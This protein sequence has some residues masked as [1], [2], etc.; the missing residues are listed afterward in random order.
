MRELLID[1]NDKHNRS[2][3]LTSP[4]CQSLRDHITTS[5]CADKLTSIDQYIDLAKFYFTGSKLNQLTGFDQFSHVDVILGCTQ[6]I[7]SLLIRYGLSGLQIL[8]GD[9]RYYWRLNPDL[10]TA[11]VGALEPNK[12]LLISMPFV[13]VSDIHPNMDSI[14]D[15]C[16][17][18][19]IPVH[20]D[21]AWVTCSKGIVFDYSH[22][23][24]QSFAMSQS[25][26]MDLGWNRIGLRWSRD[27]TPTDSISIYNQFTMIPTVNLAIGVAYLQRIQPDHLW[28]QYGDMYNKVCRELYLR[29]TKFIHVAKS[30]DRKHN[31]SLKNILE[32][33]V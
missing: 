10:K 1:H 22:P 15:E 24:I 28:N 32:H 17:S 9:Y 18:K 14:L 12:P 16:S 3:F 4:E 11:V 33:R 8:D 6:F 27:A 13:G 26:G 2:I 25:K 31:Y 29:P 5:V 23:A 7:D 21:S 30:M 19:N 20:I